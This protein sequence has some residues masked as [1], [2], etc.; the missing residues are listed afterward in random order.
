MREVPQGLVGSWG[1]EVVT[2]MNWNPLQKLPIER[3]L[4]PARVTPVV[5]WDDMGPGDSV[6]IPA[7]SEYEQE[8]FLDLATRANQKYKRV[9]KFIARRRSRTVEKGGEKVK[10]L[11]VRIWRVD[12]VLKIE[13]N[14]PLPAAHHGEPLDWSR[15]QIGDSVYITCKDVE[16]QEYKLKRAYELNQILPP[17]QFVA[18]TAKYAKSIG[19]RVWRVG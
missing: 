7:I 8:L 4:I 11:G 3:R 2:D 13:K 12:G 18:H 10:E 14:K 19:V 6:F 16:H 15:L 5:P 9:R 1:L 17:R